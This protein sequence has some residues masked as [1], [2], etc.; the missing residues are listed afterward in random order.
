MSTSDRKRG[1]SCATAKVTANPPV[2]AQDVPFE[3]SATCCGAYNTHD[4]V[5]SAS[6]IVLA[7]AKTP[8]TFA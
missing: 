2:D 5:T 3:R 8:F 6:G 4:Q 1:H 7:K